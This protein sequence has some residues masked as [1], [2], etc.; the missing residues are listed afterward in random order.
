MSV[1]EVTST[2]TIFDISKPRILLIIQY[3][4]LFWTRS[5]T[6]NIDIG[7]VIKYIVLFFVCLTGFHF[8]AIAGFTYFIIS[9][10]IESNKEKVYKTPL[11]DMAFISVIMM[12][13]V[14]EFVFDKSFYIYFFLLI[15][16]VVFFSDIRQLTVYRLYAIGSIASYMGFFEYIQDL[17]YIIVGFAIIYYSFKYLIVSNY[18]NVQNATFIRIFDKIAIIRSQRTEVMLCYPKKDFQIKKLQSVCG[19]DSFVRN[20]R[21]INDFFIFVIISIYFI[22][23][24]IF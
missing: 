9:E 22:H 10:V 18:V 4:L 12:F 16:G 19:R 5:L 14:Y 1:V 23:S 21:P 7:D 13:F 20:Y 24:F 8:V 2:I 3:F 11:V 17:L 15:S 6:D